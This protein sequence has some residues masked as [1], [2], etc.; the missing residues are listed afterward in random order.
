MSPITV[1][2]GSSI[3]PFELFFL[4]HITQAYP[5]FVEIISEVVGQCGEEEVLD[6]LCLDQRQSPTL[7]FTI[8]F[9]LG[10]SPR[11]RQSKLVASA[12]EHLEVRV[13]W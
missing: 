6:I 5:D 8:L 1:G 4:V 2:Q 10:V 12:S 9:G 3:V 11:I 7:T 13:F